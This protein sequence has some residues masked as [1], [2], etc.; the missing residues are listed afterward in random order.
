MM[1]TSL[2]VLLGLLLASTS[3]GAV[4]GES[5]VPSYLKNYAELYRSDPHAAGMKW[6]D[7]AK[8]GLFMHYGVYPT[9]RRSRDDGW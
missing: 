7:D 1:W 5:D 3:L 6:F 2:R 4:T 9:D 8:Y